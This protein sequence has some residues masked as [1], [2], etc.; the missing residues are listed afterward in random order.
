MQLTRCLQYLLLGEYQVTLAND[1]GIQS[2]KANVSVRK[3][4]QPPTFTQKFSD[5]Q[6]LPTY[7][8]KFMARVAGVPKPSVAWTFNGQDLSESTKYRIKRDGDVCA[9]FIRDCNAASAGRY[10]CIAT[11]SEGQD[12]CEAVLEV[13]D[14][15]EKKE[16]EQIPHFLKK[17][18][19]CEV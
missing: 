9:I 2:A 1:N 12:R 13:V 19:D 3:I 7:D 5:L 18:G 16:K 6:Q 15:I 17:I 10:A 4:Y 14:K 8:A 11:N